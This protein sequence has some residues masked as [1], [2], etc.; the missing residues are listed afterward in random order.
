V[1]VP[2]VS[3]WGHVGG[4]LGGFVYGV[5]RLR[6]PLG[7]RFADAAGL[8]SVA[9]LALAVYASLSTVLPLLP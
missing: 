1:A 3:L 4:V 7:R 8:L 2:G 5:V 9:L 6:L